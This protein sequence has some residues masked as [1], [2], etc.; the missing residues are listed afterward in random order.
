MSVTR[1]GGNSCYHRS[2]CISAVFHHLSFLTLVAGESRGV[3]K[4]RGLTQLT[5][6]YAHHI[7]SLFN[8]VSCKWNRLHLVQRFF[9]AQYRCLCLVFQPAICRA[10]NV[11][12]V[13]KFVSFHEFF[14][15]RKQQ[16][17]LGA[18][19]THLL[20]RQLKHWLSSKCRFWT[21][22]RENVCNNSKNVKSHVYW[23]LKKKRKNVRIISQAT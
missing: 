22:V 1:M 14:Q 2:V 23:I 10:D 20:T 3:Q 11:L 8:I 15:F 13:R 19:T 7:L 16:K 21:S 17:S 6:R 12:V 4:V 18:R 9:N 5:T